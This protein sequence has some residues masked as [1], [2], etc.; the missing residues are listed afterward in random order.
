MPPELWIHSTMHAARE[1]QEASILVADKVG[2]YK[3]ERVLNSRK[4]KDKTYYL[5]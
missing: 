4:R 1:P 2:E 5:V 3:I